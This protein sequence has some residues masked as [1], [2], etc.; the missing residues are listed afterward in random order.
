MV[1]QHELVE[2]VK[3]YDPKFDEAVLNRAYTFSKQAHGNQT[4]ESGALYFSHPAARAGHF[5]DVA[6]SQD[7]D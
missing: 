7:L 6:G 3:A 4:R 1:G 5:D 2:R